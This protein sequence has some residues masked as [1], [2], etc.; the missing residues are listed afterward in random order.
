M[1]QY[2]RNAH[3]NEYMCKELFNQSINDDIK[4][5]SMSGYRS[6][7]KFGSVPIADTHNLSH[8]VRNI[9]EKGEKPFFINRLILLSGMTV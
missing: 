6:L 5:I 4:Q 9:K 7:P 1:N 2:A 3:F 8:L